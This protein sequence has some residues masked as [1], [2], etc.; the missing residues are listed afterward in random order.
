MKFFRWILA[1]IALGLLGYGFH[2]AMTV[3]ADEAMFNVQRIFYYHIPAW[4]MTSLCFG[5]NLIGSVVYLA[6]RNKRP[7]LALRADAVAL[8]TAE[9]G[10]VFW[11]V[12]RGRYAWGIWWTW[13]E[14]LTSTLI[15][16]LIYVSY[17]LLRNFS[18]GPQMRTVSAVLAI[19]GYIDVPIVYMSTRW[20]RTQH[21]APVFFG[22]PGSGIAASMKPAVTWNVYAWMA[23][24]L[25]VI[26]IRYAVERRQQQIDEA[27]ALQSLNDPAPIEVTS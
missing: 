13:D 8:A 24:A 17:L 14:R 1:I 21:P 7:T 12:G 26:S 15:L 2:I 25:L 4:I 18:A 23:W 3:P 22:A 11:H 10:V 5:A 27:A 6:A 19:F 9:M 20:W 16:W